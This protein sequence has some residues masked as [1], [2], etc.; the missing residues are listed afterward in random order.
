M[1]EDKALVTG[2]D[3]RN[4]GPDLTLI[5]QAAQDPSVDVAKVSAL[6]GLYERMQD[7]QAEQLFNSAMVACQREMPRVTKDGKLINY[8]TGK[9]QSRYA[10]IERIDSIVR[11]IYERYGFSVSATIDSKEGD[12]YWVKGIVR[13]DGGHREDYRIPLALDQTGNK[14]DTQGMGST[15]SYGRRYL[16]CAIFNIITEGQDTDGAAQVDLVND[17]QV[18]SLN[19]FAIE[20]KANVAAFCKYLGIEKLADLPAARYEEAMGELRKKLKR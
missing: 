19:D 2:S 5:M 16:L 3:T 4:Q 9:V 8:K 20:V 1:A 11:S 14:N 10:T 18:M 7:R 13:H 17:E 12:K 6:I 15:L